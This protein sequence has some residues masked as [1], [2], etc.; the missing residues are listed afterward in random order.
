MCILS[1]VD[2]LIPHSFYSNSSRLGQVFL[3]Q[4]NV[5]ILNWVLLGKPVSVAPSP[6]YKSLSLDMVVGSIGSISEGK[7]T[8]EQNWLPCLFSF[9][10]HRIATLLFPY[11][12]VFFSWSWNII[13][14]VVKLLRI[15][16]SQ[17]LVALYDHNCSI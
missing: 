7:E 16:N 13:L 14:K 9:L 4:R 2:P 3:L 15:V 12:F 11:S 6:S 1:C 5:P 8:W 10:F 17:N